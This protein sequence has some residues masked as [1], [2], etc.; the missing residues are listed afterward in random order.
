MVVNSSFCCIE[1]LTEE[2]FPFSLQL[3]LVGGSIQQGAINMVVTK[4]T[5]Q[6]QKKKCNRCGDIFK[7]STGY[8]KIAQ[9]DDNFPDQH[10]NVCKKCL[11]QEWDDEKTGFYAFIDFLRVAN[12]PYKHDVYN[13]TDK[14]S[15]IKRIRLTHKNLRFRDSDSLLE[16][17]SEIQIQT[18]NL[19]ELT[20]E[21]ME[22]CALFWGKGYTEEEYIYLMETYAQFEREFDLSSIT[23]KRLVV[24][25]VTLDLKIRRGNEQGISVKDDLKAYQEVLASA[26]LK[27]SQEKAAAENEANTFGTFIKRI[28]DN[29][30]IP[31]PDAK[32][33]D[34]DGII[35][36]VK[37]FFLG[38][39][40]RALGEKNP[41]QKE[42]DEVLQ[43]LTVDYEDGSG[44]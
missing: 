24:Q 21:Q 16:E 18:N 15:Y 5:S 19:K 33:Q 41:Y 22:D 35:K 9:P 28:E 39:M 23:M 2:A 37:V 17:K 25:A 43:E 3:F 36:Y 4:T 44:K 8:Y 20:V 34:V 11:K 10:M 7:T 40:A 12:L 29:Q 32:Y 1:P 27:P 42:T 13:S 38:A 30:P 26:S 14:I 6:Q 31:E